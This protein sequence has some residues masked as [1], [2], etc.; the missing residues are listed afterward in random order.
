MLKADKSETRVIDIPFR[1]F[2]PG[3]LFEDSF[4]LQEGEISFRLEVFEEF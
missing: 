1:N 4:L 2:V 3:D